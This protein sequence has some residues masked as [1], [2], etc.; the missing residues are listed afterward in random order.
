MLSLRA[1]AIAGGSG[2]G[3]LTATGDVT[4]FTSVDQAPDSSFFIE[5]MDAGN[6]L[7][8][9]LR[10]KKRMVEL[11]ALQ[12]GDRVLEVGCGTGDDA[13]DLHS[14]VG[15][16]GK[17]F[18]IDVSAAMIETAIERSESAGIAVDFRKADALALPF[19]DGHFDA[20]RC[21]RVLMHLDGAPADAITEM[22][23]TTRAG[24]RVVISDFDWDAA[25][26]DHPDRSTTRQI[27]HTVS[28]GIRHGQVGRQLYHLLIDAGLTDVEIESHGI[29]LTHE[30]LHQ[31]LDGH[32]RTAEAERRLEPQT[33][34]SWW[35]QLAA[36]DTGGRFLTIWTAVLGTGAVP[37]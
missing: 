12:P 27:V 25:M 13:R 23:R 3:E 22:A 21:E 14:V 6:A 20:C 8:D 34:R 28:D 2:M 29:R 11:L 36:A 10:L 5:F 33:V 9:V 26:I 24:G 16:R 18:G 35:N 1:M 19:P 31:L 32:L 30:F 37:T 7:A 17:V 15:E 4:R